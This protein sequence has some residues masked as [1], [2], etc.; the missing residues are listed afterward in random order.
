MAKKLRTVWKFSTFVFTPVTDPAMSERTRFAKNYHDLSTDNGYQ[1]EFFCEHCGN[2]YRS[3]LQS[4]LSARASQILNAANNLL[5]GVLG[6]GSQEE[7]GVRDSGWEKA[8]E[9]AFQDATEELSP[10]FIQCPQCMKW[11]C[12]EE[13]WNVKKGQCRDCAPEKTT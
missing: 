11:V 6:A 7:T 3:T 1:F 4:S 8:H 12:R 9:K 5:G 2:G 13:C 10:R